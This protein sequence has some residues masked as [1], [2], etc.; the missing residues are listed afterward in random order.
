MSGVYILLA[1]GGSKAFHFTVEFL[2]RHC[3]HLVSI[4]NIFGTASSVGVERSSRIFETVLGRYVYL[5][6]LSQNYSSLNTVC[7]RHQRS[8]EIDANTRI[9]TTTNQYFSIRRDRR[10]PTVEVVSNMMIMLSDSRQQKGYYLVGA[11]NTREHTAV[12]F[13]QHGG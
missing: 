13:R 8:R 4:T 10:T 7:V 12:R 3:R 5:N 1:L 9:S 6:D 2:P 11:A